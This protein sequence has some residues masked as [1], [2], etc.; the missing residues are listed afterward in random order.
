MGRAPQVRDINFQLEQQIFQRWAFT[1]PHGSKFEDMME[2]SFWASVA[3]KV[4]PWDVIAVKAEDHSFWGE[5]LVLHKEKFSLQVG[6]LRYFELDKLET[7]VA[8]GELAL[9]QNDYRIEFD[10]KNKWKCIRKSDNAQIFQGHTSKEF[11]EKALKDY[12]AELGE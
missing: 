7:K 2:P 9:S 11:A 10:A 12:I 4:Q 5:L 3:H 6:K 8:K 1:A